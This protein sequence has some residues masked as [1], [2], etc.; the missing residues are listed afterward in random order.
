MSEWCN[1]VVEKINSGT[2]NENQKKNEINVK[3]E[4]IGKV[5]ENL[6]NIP[7][8]NLDKYPLVSTKHDPNFSEPHAI[9]FE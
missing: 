9:H 6:E 5:V 1:K 7:N 8:N 4:M 2:E 3:Q